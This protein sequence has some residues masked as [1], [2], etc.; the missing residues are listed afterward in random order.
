LKILPLAVYAIPVERAP[1]AVRAAQ[2]FRLSAPSKR[3]QRACVCEAV[4]A[5]ASATTAVAR[6]DSVYRDRIRIST[7]PSYGPSYRNMLWH[8][9]GVPR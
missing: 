6:L 2:G 3:R 5:D 9:L 1:T 4:V 7:R 8:A